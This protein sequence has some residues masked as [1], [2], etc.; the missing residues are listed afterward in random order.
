MVTD[1]NDGGPARQK[2]TA[3]FVA[4]SN[5]WHDAILVA[6]EAAALFPPDSKESLH[7]FGADTVVRAIEKAA[8]NVGVFVIGGEA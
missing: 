3:Q 1:K 5:V 2:S 7:R 6:R 4:E 8:A